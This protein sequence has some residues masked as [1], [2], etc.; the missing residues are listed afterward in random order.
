MAKE[1]TKLFKKT[2]IMTTS[3][4]NDDVRDSLRKE[5]YEMAELNGYEPAGELIFS[6][7]SVASEFTVMG[8][9]KKI[10]KVYKKKEK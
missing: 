4:L 7:G 9:F 10:K 8:D 1:N 3:H 5:I 6:Q 2:S